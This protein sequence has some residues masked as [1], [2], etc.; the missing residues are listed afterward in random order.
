M[1]SFHFA[2]AFLPSI[3]PLEIIIRGT[4]VYIFIFGLLRLALK[5]QSGNVSM[6]DLLVLVL[7]ADAAQNSM[8]GQY[9]SIT[10]GLLLVS[11]IVFWSFVIDWL[12]FHLEFFRHLTEPPPLLLIQNGKM[13]RQNM[14]KELITEEELKSQL[15]QRGI[16]DL[17]MVKRAHIEPDG[18]ISVLTR[19]KSS[20]GK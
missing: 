18:S 13:L 15:R 4:V 7:I 20:I 9:K 14:R 6:N 8:T 3:S 16:E 2:K 5:R 19:N 10:D 1:E 12:G 17:S 11:T